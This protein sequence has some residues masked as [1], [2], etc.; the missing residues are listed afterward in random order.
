MCDRRNETVFIDSL[1]LNHALL[2]ICAIYVDH[3]P[4][5]A[6][7]HFSYSAMARE[8]ADK[9]Y[10]ESVFATLQNSCY[11][12]LSDNSRAIGH[13]QELVSKNTQ[14]L[15]EGFG[16]GIQTVLKRDAAGI[17]DAIGLLTKTTKKKGWEGKFSGT[18]TVFTG[19]LQNDKIMV[20]QGLAALLA[21]HKDQD[22]I[23]VF[24]DFIN[25]EATALVK[26]AWRQGME[27]NIDSPLVPKQLLPVQE[28]PEY[29]GFEF[30]SEL[31]Y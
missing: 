27:V 23:V 3:D 30:F 10:D 19:L 16:R 1:D 28:C 12:L 11:A 14:T 24:K 6:R 7:Q 29:P 20:E 21:A 2:A 4:V 25:L 26:L 8:Y 31:G 15:A 5:L 13:Y 9:K 22:H 17:E 18:V